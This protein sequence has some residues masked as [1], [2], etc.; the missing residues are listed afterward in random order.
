VEETASPVPGPGELLVDVKA[1]GVNFPDVLMIQNKYQH[2]P[3]LPFAPG[4]ELA[5]TVRQLGP[6]VSGFNIGDAG[7]AIVRSGGF[8]EQAVVPA[9]RFWRLPRDFD[10][11][12]AAAFPLAYGTS[13]HALKERARLMPGETLVVLGAAGGV[14]LAAVQIGKAMGARVIACASSDDKLATCKRHGADELINYSTQ[15]LREAIKVLTA[16]GGVDVVLDP[17]GG[18][19]A[20]PCVRSM[21]WN[22]RYLVVGFAAGDIP[23]IPLNLVLLKGCSIVGVAWD[24]YSR[25]NPAG[26]QTNVDEMIAWITAG[27]LKPV[28]TA[29]YTLDNAARALDDVMQRR[30]QGK[31]VI[32][33]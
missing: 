16:D 3:P 21:A 29:E 17:I 5:G 18:E 28:V 12:I 33:P 4:Y 24:T 22:G 26:G 2:R 23:R 19:Y 32:V 1:A 30:V 27:K 14:G 25:R 6:G 20:E 13:Y 15:N 7:V 8:A 31:V 9:D 10:F 11:R